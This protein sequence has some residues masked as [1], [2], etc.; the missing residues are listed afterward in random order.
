MQGR[1]CCLFYFAIKD[2]QHN[3]LTHSNDWWPPLSQLNMQIKQLKQGYTTR[4]KM[5]N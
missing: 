4:V 2:K 5:M 3:M 1:Q